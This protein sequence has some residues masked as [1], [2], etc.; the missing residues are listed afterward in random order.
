MKKK[1]TT[2]KDILK[3]ARNRIIQIIIENIQRIWKELADH[4]PD[5][6]AGEEYEIE[7][8]NSDILS[9]VLVDNPYGAVN[10]DVLET[11]TLEKITMDGKYNVRLHFSPFEW[12]GDE[13]EQK[14]VSVHAVDDVDIKTDTLGQVATYLENYKVV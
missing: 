2:A 1:K 7:T 8:E 4:E 11:R 12:Y 3:D 6:D 14:P 13:D 10:E 9:E 5:F